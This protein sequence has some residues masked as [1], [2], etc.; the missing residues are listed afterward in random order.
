MSKLEGLEKKKRALEQEIETERRRETGGELQAQYKRLA[1][2]DPLVV[3]EQTEKALQ[4][5]S[6]KRKDGLKPA[7]LAE[8]LIAARRKS[9]PGS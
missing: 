2:A 7:T 4:F 1:S 5:V 9:I 8:G 6:G 3:Y